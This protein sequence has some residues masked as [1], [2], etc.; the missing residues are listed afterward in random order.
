MMR[1][2]SVTVL[3]EP[4]GVAFEMSNSAVRGVG[5]AVDLAVEP[6]LPGTLITVPGRIFVTSLMPLTRCSSV[7]LTLYLRAMP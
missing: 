7:T 3:G 4:I 6:P 2:F 1:G 5:V